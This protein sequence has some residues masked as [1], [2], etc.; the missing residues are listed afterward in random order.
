MHTKRVGCLG[1]RYK[2][3]YVF[4]PA[5]RYIKVR[6]LLDI[7]NILEVRLGAAASQLLI[8]WL[9]GLSWMQLPIIVA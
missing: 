5:A 1:A 8:V 7:C 2:S 9:C 4:W 3:S 6:G